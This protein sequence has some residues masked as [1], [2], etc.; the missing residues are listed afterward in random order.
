MRVT[1]KLR[2][3]LELLDSLQRI[4]GYKNNKNSKEKSPRTILLQKISSNDNNIPIK[5]Q[6]LKTKNNN[7]INKNVF[8]PNINTNTNINS[9]S[10]SL[11]KKKIPFPKKDMNYYNI[12]NNKNDKNY[13][14]NNNSKDNIKQLKNSFIST[15]KNNNNRLISESPLSNIKYK[16]ATYK[17]INNINQSPIKKTPE[18][19]LNINNNENNENNNYLNNLKEHKIRN[20]LSKNLAYNKKKA[21]STISSPNVELG[22]NFQK[23]GYNSSRKNSSDS[24]NNSINN[25]N[26]NNNNEYG[27]KT[28]IGRDNYSVNSFNNKNI[29]SPKT[30]S[31]VTDIDSNN[32]KNTKNNMNNNINNNINN[33]VFKNN[34]FIDIKLEDIIIFEERLNDIIIA[35]NHGS[36]HNNNLNNLTNNK[37]DIGASNECYEIFSFYFNSSLK[38][39]FPLFFHEPNRIIIQSAINLKLFIIMITYHLSINPPMIIK[40]LDDLKLIY[41]LLKQNLYLLIKKL[42]I[43]YGEAFIL[44]NEKYFKIFNY[45]LSRNGLNNLNE[46]EI[47]EIINQNCCN[48]VKNISNI[49]NY[50]KA[51]ANPFYLDFY[52]LFN[53]LSRLTEKDINNYFYT[54]LYGLKKPKNAYII[55]KNNNL[56]YNINNI[57]INKIRNS[58]NINNNNNNYIDNNKE[59]LDYQKNKIPSPYITVP[60]TKKYTLVLDLDNTLISHNDNNSNDMCNLRPGLLSFLNTLKPI[61]ELISFTN[62]SKE[63]SDQLLKEIESNRKYF[64]YN[65]YREHNILMDNKL[66]KDISKIGRDMKKIIIIDKSI[67]N[68][69]NTPQN[70]ILIKPYYGE[71]NKNDTVLFELK[72]LLIL[73]HKMGYEDL[74]IAIKNYA[75]DI[76]YKITLDNNK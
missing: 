72:K 55:N 21:S 61:Y 52:E 6:L 8:S 73:F 1:K 26:C 25:I 14:E 49:L 67:D 7:I 3:E 74:R 18:I 54:Y 68:I 37:Y 2:S 48:I 27:T 57:N 12:Y 11:N 4:S 28:Y 20:V 58:N 41:S 38:Y 39:K 69:K 29:N 75:T 16:N 23:I 70:G 19:N 62:E 63:Y 66:V 45:I 35:L 44:Q 31:Y 13:K 42:N 64:D 10:L 40:L 56:K 43:F 9:Y 51:I 46:N 76:K 5:V 50:Y 17:S 71:T 24:N 34:F 53:I 30:P 47:K 65:L 60:T 15:N 36:T 59:I 32:L 22:G 33:N